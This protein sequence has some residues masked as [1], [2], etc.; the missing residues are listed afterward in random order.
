ML[1]DCRCAVVVNFLFCFFSLFFV[2]S[3]YSPEWFSFSVCM[4]FV[5]FSFF[6]YIFDTFIAAFHVCFPP[7]FSHRLPPST[8][9]GGG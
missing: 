8:F 3:S 7:F 4:C 1:V 9:Y 6:Q 5:L 2:F